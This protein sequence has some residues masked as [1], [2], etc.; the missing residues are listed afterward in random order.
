[1]PVKKV[2]KKFEVNKETYDTEELANKAYMEY[3]DAA[4][5]IKKSDAKPKKKPVAAG[6]K[7]VE[8]EGDHDY[9]D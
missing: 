4:F 9:R 5:D 3:L 1:M 6:K 2:G 8:D 7:K